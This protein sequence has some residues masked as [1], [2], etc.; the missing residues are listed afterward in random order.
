MK[1]ADYSYLLKIDFR[2]KNCRYNRLFQFVYEKNNLQ[3]F[4]THFGE[5]N[6]QNSSFQNWVFLM[7]K[8]LDKIRLT[9]QE[10]VTQVQYQSSLINEFRVEIDGLAKNQNETKEFSVINQT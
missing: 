10:I 8:L 4:E 2:L 3:L 9:T 1:F 7:N 6:K 5:K